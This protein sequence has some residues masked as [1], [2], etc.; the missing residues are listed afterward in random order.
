MSA[1]PQAGGKA[2]AHD[3]AEAIGGILDEPPRFGNDVLRGGTRLTR[4]WS[5]G[6]FHAALPA[7]ETH[8][9]MTYYGAAQGSGWRQE[10]RHLRAR[11][12]PGTVTII[13]EGQDGRWD[14]EG[15]IEVSHVY[16]TD[17]RLQGAA[18]SF[19]NGRPVEL[20]GRIC[21]DDL[22]A[23][24]ILEVLSHEAAAGDASSS[25]FAEQA[26]DLLCAQLVRAHSGSAA[27]SPPARKG[28][29]DWQVKRVTD[30]MTDFLD[31]EIRLDDLAALVDLSRFHFVT[32]FRLATGQTP[33][34]WLTALRIAQSKRLLAD[35]TTPI[36]TIALAVG[37]QT[38][39]SFASTFRK[40]TGSTPSAFR[41]AA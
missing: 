26:L 32:A 3:A 39:S 35:R 15:P 13:P 4:R 9:I 21:A 16:L 30:Y 22:V 1:R 28:L 8:V 41:A 7:M 33:H 5:H 31:T 11:T 24:R 40:V 34:E 27:P 12:R 19:G 18:E 10:G 23:A 38:P 2:Q 14:V 37:Y 36:T 29:A 20:L 25:L 6:E 17:A